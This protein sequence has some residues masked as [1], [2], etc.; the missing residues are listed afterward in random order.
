MLSHSGASPGG[1]TIRLPSVANA[2]IAAMSAP[3]SSKSNIAMLCSSRSIREVLES[4]S[5]DSCS[6]RPLLS[7]KFRFLECRTPRRIVR[8]RPRCDR[9][10]RYRY[11]GIRHEGRRGSEH[12]KLVVVPDDQMPQGGVRGILV[13]AGNE[14]VFRSQTTAYLTGELT[15]SG[16]AN[17]FRVE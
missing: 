3:S 11:D 10:A 13:G 4:G 12:D 1:S 16:P 14:M 7:E 15:R 5:L 6:P 9:F 8:F 17:R 2:C